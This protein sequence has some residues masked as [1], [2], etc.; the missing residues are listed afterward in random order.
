MFPADRQRFLAHWLN[1]P[2]SFAF[3]MR[4]EDKICGYGVIRPCRTGY[5]IGPLFAD[6]YEI[7]ERI[8]LHLCHETETNTKIY[9]DVPEVNENGIRLAKQHEMQKIFG[10]ARMYTAKAPE[11]DLDKIF[12]VTT[13]ELG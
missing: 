11:L 2:E 10:T 3:A 5:K 12:G 13:F 9:I 6:S 7:A 1:M 4:K 8:F